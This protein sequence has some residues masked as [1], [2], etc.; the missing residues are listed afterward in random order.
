MRQLLLLCA[1]LLSGCAASFEESRSAGLTE[2]GMGYSP[3]AEVEARCRALDDQ[4]LVWG[5]IGK[6][7]G[8]LSGGAGLSTI[9]VED[10]DAQVAL[11]ASSAGLLAFSL[12]ATYVADAK[13]EEWARECS[14]R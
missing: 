6:G 11:A 7:T 10:R 13:G 3:S 8:V 1:P 14:Q 4:R 9:P 5:A 12:V 2:R